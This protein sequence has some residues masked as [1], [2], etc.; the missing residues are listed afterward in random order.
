MLDG[1]QVRGR[2]VPHA[3]AQWRARHYRD[4]RYQLSFDLHEDAPVL[5]GRLVLDLRLPREPV[6]LVL[7]WCGEP[8]RNVTVNG[9]P[10]EAALEHE[11]LVLPAR[12][13]KGGRN[14]IALAF[15]APVAAADAPVTRFE[16]ATDATTY[17]YTLLV[18]ADARRLFPCFDQPDLRGRYAL[19]LSLPPGW[20]AVANAPLDRI[21]GNTHAFRE[22]EPLPTYLFAFATGAFETITLPG[23]AVRLFVRR[24]RFADAQAQATEILGLNRRMLD[25]C[26]AWVDHPFPFAKYDLVLVPDFPYGGMEHAG[27][28]F[29]NEDRLL[30]PSPAE[31][32]EQLRRVQLLFHETA[33]QWF[34][35]LVTM[36][37]FDDLWLKEGFANDFASR[38]IAALC[39][40]FDPAIAF[41]AMKQSAV[42]TDATRG[43]T[44]LHAPL[45]NLA[46]AKSAY[47]AIVYCKGPAV[48]RQAAFAFGEDAFQRAV[49]DFLR[50]HAYGAADSRDFILALQRATGKNLR[51]WA[52]AW[53]HRRGLPVV[54]L[55]RGA[56]RQRDALGE[57]GLWPQRLRVATGADEIDVR[58]DRRPVPVGSEGLV[59][60]NAGDFG[61]GRFLL[62]PNGLEAVMDPA[63]HPATPLLRAQLVDAAWEAVRDADLAPLRFLEFGL[64]QLRATED[65]IALASLLACMEHAFRRFLSR[66]QRDAFAPALEAALA[67]AAEDRGATAPRALRLRQAA[68]ATAWSRE[69][70]QRLLGWIDGDRLAPRERYL[71]LQRLALL[72]D[73]EGTGRLDALA[74]AVPVGER[75][76][77]SLLVRAT[78]PEAKAAVLQR[79]IDDDRLPEAWAQST[80]APLHAPEHHKATRPLLEA[81][82][83]ALPALKQRRKIFF[84]GQWL[85]AT[86]D[87]QLSEQALDHVRAFLARDSLAPDLQRQAQVAIDGL[88]RTVQVRRRFALTP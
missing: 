51:R 88:E 85:A 56:L 65:A 68:L 30:L 81:A 26:A 45:E 59:F 76:R 44:P 13:L 48:L 69:G 36:R 66:A 50:R 78:R 40:G 43:T 4:V 6:D 41:H 24:S 71:A 49:R 73:A 15:E 39:P 32:S 84:T 31:A 5:Q 37:W 38:A 77:V 8:V 9:Q 35:N 70:R 16:D 10:A 79:L 23:E 64:R 74:R 87:G 42:R 25:W 67:A 86:L 21:E 19:A 18:P 3:L 72:G 58:L 11:H 29:L 28:T 7:D 80:L 12:F 22:T 17:L 27:A 75:E 46:D 63:F 2:G 60:P 54:H 55:E 61:Y 33:H 62:D 52:E 83:G 20:V 34:G 1:S 53:I 47:S 82:L 14:R 57:G